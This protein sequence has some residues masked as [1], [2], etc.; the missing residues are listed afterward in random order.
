[1]PDFSTDN[2]DYVPVAMDILLSNN[3]RLDCFQVRILDNDRFEDMENF[4][5]VISNTVSSN[6]DF[7][8][9]SNPRIIT[10]E[11]DDDDRSTTIGFSETLYRV[12][13]SDSVRVC[14]GVTI[15]PRT[16]EFVSTDNI[17]LFVTTLSGTAGT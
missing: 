8:V 7:R 17:R 2:T 5:I 11:I 10:V 4:T 16:E 14:V 12:N 3:L 6:I 15:P 1:M 13:E 9:L